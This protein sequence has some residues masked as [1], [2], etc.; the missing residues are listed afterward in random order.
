MAL[1]NKQD[2]RGEIIA[3]L[4]QLA[5]YYILEK[6]IASVIDSKMHVWAFE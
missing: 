1:R 5:I 2:I 6:P 3:Q 4:A